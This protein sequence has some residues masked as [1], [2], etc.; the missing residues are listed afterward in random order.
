M[1]TKPDNQIKPVLIVCSKAF[2][3]S[4]NSHNIFLDWRDNNVEKQIGRKKNGDD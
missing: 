2:V 4:S 3:A 1:Y